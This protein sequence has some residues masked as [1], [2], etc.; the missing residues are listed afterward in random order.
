MKTTIDIAE[1]LLNAA[2]RLAREQDRTLRDV[3]EEAL[4]RLLAQ[5]EEPR[6]PFRLKRGAVH[7][8]GLQ[9]GIVEGQWW[10]LIYPMQDVATLDDSGR[11]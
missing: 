3:V 1:S 9:P 8:R 2:K 5:Q 7:G 4:R 10:D 11:H 6:K